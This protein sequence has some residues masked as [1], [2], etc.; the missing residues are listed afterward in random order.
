MVFGSAKWALDFLHYILNGLFDLAEE[1]EG[2]EGEAFTQ[3]GKLFWEG[4]DVG[5]I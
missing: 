4:F 5:P 1:V 2:L 3:K